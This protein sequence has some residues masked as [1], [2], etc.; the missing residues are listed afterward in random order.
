MHTYGHPCKIDEIK[1]ICKKYKIFL[2][3]D[4]AESLGSKYKNKHTGTFG[5]LGTFSF[6]GNKIITSGG[7]GCI[8]TNSKVLAKKARHLSTTAKVSH[9]WEFNHNMIG[10]NYRLPNLNA[11]LLVAQMENLDNFLL[12]KRKIANSYEKYFNDINCNFF[13]EPFNS[14][15]NY[16]LNSIIFENKKQRDDFLKFSNDNGVMTRPAWRLMNNLKMFNQSESTKL[17]NARYFEK[18]L[19]NIPSSV[20]V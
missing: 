12:K 3:E 20:I 7:G 17:T 8:L 14:K 18:R 5:D 15:S 9:K 4:A 11:A 19:V 16:W 10:Y 2:I 1:D 13:K 6:N